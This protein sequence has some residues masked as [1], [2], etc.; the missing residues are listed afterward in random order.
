MY[1]GRNH[2]SKLPNFILG[3]QFCD[4]ISNRE[5][6]FYFGNRGF[7][8][9]YEEKYKPGR[10][11]FWQDFFVAEADNDEIKA[12]EKYFEK[13]QEYYDWYISQHRQ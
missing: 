6:D 3:Y 1:L 7:L 8:T 11:S 2:I 4:R 5:Q 9:W 10:M 12:L 13:L